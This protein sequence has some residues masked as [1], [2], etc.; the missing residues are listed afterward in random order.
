MLFKHW[1]LQPVDGPEPAA[2]C[3]LGF[4]V[5]SVYIPSSTPSKSFVT[6]SAS[7]N[8]KPIG[9]PADDRLGIDPFAKSLAASILKMSAPEGTV[10]ALH[11]PWGSGKSSAVNL[12]RH[13]L[14]N[15]TDKGELVVIDFAPWWFGGEDALALAFYRELYDGLSPTLGERFKKAWPQIGAKLLRAGSLVG[16][17]ADLVAPT[18]VGAVASGAM[19][20]LAGLIA[21]GGDTI[22]KLHAQL[23]AALNDQDKRF[24]IIID[25]IDRLSPD[26]ALL[27]FRL[28]KSVGCLPN[29]IYLLVFDRLL[30]EAIVKERFPSEGPHYLEKIVQAAFDLPE[31]APEKLSKQLLEQIDG[32]CGSPSEDNIV[33][34]MN[35]FYDVV[36]PEIRTPR[37]LIRL[38]NAI[39]VTW[40]AIGSD[41]DQAD[42]IALETLRL[43]Q[44]Q[45]YRALRSNKEKLC[46]GRHGQKSPDKGEYDRLFFGSAE[47]PDLA[48]KQRALMRI[49]PTL[50]SVWSNVLHGDSSANNWSRDR[51]ACSS[52]HFGTYFR[53][54][55]GEE[56]V[57]KKTI[58]GLIEHGKDGAFVEQ[59][60]TSALKETRSDGSTGAALLL[61]ELNLHA[62]KVPADSVQ[63]LLT[64]LFRLADT[65]DVE[66]DRSKAFAIGDNYLRIH[67]LL[68]RLTNERFDLARR[69]AILLEAAKSASIGWLVDLAN[70]AYRDHHPREGGEPN[71][72]RIILLTESDTKALQ[73]LALDAI[74]AAAESGVLLD[75]PR[76]APLLF[77]WQELA[78]D[79][80][81]EV[82]AWTATKLEDDEAIVKI[83][84]RYTSH[85]WSQ[86]LGIG[87]LGDT[88]AKRNTRAS[89]EALEEV[90]TKAGFVRASRS[91][92]PGISWILTRR[93]S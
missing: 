64:E 61:D 32:I 55:L 73:M 44:P 27:V 60:F 29:V 39:S 57:P 62:D 49:F 67:W 30:A 92:P 1:S 4:Y 38:M 70:S 45:L 6:A 16:A 3:S 34:F 87:G 53:F 76:L 81:A 52:T 79:K 65:L 77:R 7:Y 89:I 15:A 33:R 22:E 8:D 71:P 63:P 54:S 40:P 10:M 21:Q 85:S 5:D 35:V 17:G 37:D 69:S 84:A 46:E 47:S 11:G 66:G 41:V 26:E 56:T 82:K 86:S 50:E 68:R 2:R 31:P 91:L 72:D 18:G 28:V 59:A 48:R 20:W 75:H 51:R 25:D 80:G 23:V 83:A 43:T 9:H 88:V 13:H 19:T 90:L 24:L 14:K 42:F 93:R 12:V 36:A 78:A 74:R 58:D